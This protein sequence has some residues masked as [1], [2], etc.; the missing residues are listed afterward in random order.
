MDELTKPIQ[1]EIP[2]CMLFVDGII[3][4][5]NLIKSRSRNEQIVMLDGHEV[6]KGDHLRYTSSIIC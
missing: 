1:D 2:W 4:N 5:V 3:W 6:L